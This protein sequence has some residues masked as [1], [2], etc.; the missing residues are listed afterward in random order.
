MLALF[1]LFLIRLKLIVDGVF[2][3]PISAVLNNV[4]LRVK[5]DLRLEAIPT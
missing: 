5:A 4:V 3:T 2:N 1:A